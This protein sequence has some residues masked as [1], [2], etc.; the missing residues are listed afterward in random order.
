MTNAD[1]DQIDG[2]G[3]VCQLDGEPVGDPIDDPCGSPLT[4]FTGSEE[5]MNLP[6]GEHT[7]EVRA[8]IVINGEQII[9]S[10]PASITWTIED[11]EVNIT[12]DAIDGNDDTV[13]NQSSTTSDDIEFTFSGMTNADPDQI[14]GQ[15]FVCQLDGEPVGDPIDDPCGS[16]LTNFTGSEEFMNLPPGEHTFEVRAFIVIN[17][18]QI[19]TSEPASITWTI[20]DIEVNITLDAIDG[21]D[22]TV[23][24]QSSTTSD[25]I[26][27]TFSGMTNA[28]PDQIDGQGFVCQLDGEPVGDP[29]DDPCGSPLTNFT[30]QVKNL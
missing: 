16:P 22:D 11:I 1:P 7:F 13:T 29:I 9:T 21:N 5:F 3:F 14:D 10:E 19:I 23:T 18:E 26:E 2:Q 15:G 20:E 8:F 24:N 28:D 30:G 4:N 17:G 6:P 12:L 25:D 27:F